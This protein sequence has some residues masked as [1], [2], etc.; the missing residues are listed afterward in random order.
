VK[1]RLF[2]AAAL[3]DS[4]RIA[5]AAAAERL[6][7]AGWAGRWIAPRS[8][9]LTVAFLGGVEDERVVAV[10]A[11][12]EES[13]TRL[14]PLTIPLDA[15]GAFPDR[16][17]PRVAWVGPRD[18][19]PAFGTLCGV[20]RSRLAALGFSFD[21]DAD[22][23]VTLARA[24]GRTALPRVAPPRTSLRVEALT[25]YESFTETTGARHEALAHVPLGAL[26]QPSV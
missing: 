22:P 7:D 20:V 17:R 10:R 1:R 25:L 21:A 11:A 5:C 13:A 24:D 12:I 23:H 6:R 8:Y 3:D 4:A 26:E 2:V 14:G 15:I 16:H 18:P 9:H 19:V